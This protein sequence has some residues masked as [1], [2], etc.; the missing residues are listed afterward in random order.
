[1]F[2]DNVPGYPDSN[3]TLGCYLGPAIDM[4][5]ALMAKILQPN[6]QF[7]CRRMLQHL[8]DTE[9]HSPVHL[10]DRHQFDTSIG[11][12]LGPAAMAQDF[13]AKDLTPDP[14]YF[15]DTHVINPDY[16]DTEITPQMSNNYLTAEIIL[17]RGGSPVKGR[18]SA[19]KRDRDGNPIGL[20]NSHPI[21]D[22]C[23][24]IVNFDNGDQTKITM[25]AESL[26]S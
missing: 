4:G 10:N 24:D 7:V 17:P 12:H 14:P 9:V 3:E 20:A 13:D 6:C 22:T 26:Y 8:T 16:G 15:D 5:S 11:T 19:C 25:I 23:S 18:I 2:R 21:V 1:M